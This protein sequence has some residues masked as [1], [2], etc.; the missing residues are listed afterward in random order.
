MEGQNDLMSQLYIT[1]GF[2]VS[3]L[4]HSV[5]WQP[6]N[7][8]AHA[9][10]NR[11]QGDLI[12]VLRLFDRAAQQSLTEPRS[13]GTSDK[14]CALSGRHIWLRMWAV[15]STGFM[16][17]CCRGRRIPLS[18]WNAIQ[19]TH[20]SRM[21]TSDHRALTAPSGSPDTRQPLTP[22]LSSVHVFRNTLVLTL[23]ATV[24]QLIMLN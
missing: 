22:P 17:H 4:L 19:N 2:S 7:E 10:W 18:H 14:P 23:L 21:K 12:K 8:H 16:S 15:D 9:Q 20:A 5:K 3:Y 6:L 11:H 1:A 24:P 13:G